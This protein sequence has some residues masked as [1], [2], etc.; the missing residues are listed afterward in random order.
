MGKLA[1]I[2]TLV[3]TMGV[4]GFLAGV[5][6]GQGPDPSECTGSSCTTSAQTG[7]GPD[8]STLKCRDCA[9]GF[10]VDD[11]ELCNGLCCAHESCFGSGDCTNPSNGKDI[12]R[13]TGATVCLVYE[14]DTS[15]CSGCQG[16]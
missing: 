4:F 12:Y 16:F 3:A 11:E 5:A 2:V 7:T 10:N 13:C 6:S 1:I 9:I 15:G 8:C 14:C